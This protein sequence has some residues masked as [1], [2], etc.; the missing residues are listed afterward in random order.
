MIILFL[1]SC[2]AHKLSLSGVIDNIEDRKTCTI[3]LITGDLVL[4]ESRLCSVAK[5]GDTVYFYGRKGVIWK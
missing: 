3:E 2:F 1:T 4:V 5:E